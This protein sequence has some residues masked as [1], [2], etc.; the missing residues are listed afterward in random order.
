MTGI[1]SPQVV[2]RIDLRAAATGPDA[3]KADTFG[4]ETLITIQRGAASG[5]A[6]DSRFVDVGRVLVVDD[7]D[8]F[9][10]HAA[11]YQELVTA[12]T[13]SRLFCLVVGAAT[14]RA[15][16]EPGIELP[17]AATSTNSAVLWV[18]DPCGVGWRLGML[19]ATRLAVSH[20]SD[21]DGTAALA[22]LV[23]TL[24]GYQIF[25]RMFGAVAELPGRAAAA[26]TLPAVRWP[27]LPVP[28]GR[29]PPPAEIVVAEEPRPAWLWLLLLAVGCALMALIPPWEVALAVWSGVLAGAAV[30]DPVRRFRGFPSRHAAMIAAATIGTAAG[31][32]AAAAADPLA[33]LG[34]RPVAA[35]C[36]SAA[37]G[38]IALAAAALVRRSS[39]G[40]PRREVRRLPAE[41][42]GADSPDPP[43]AE[44][45]PPDSAEEDLAAM[46]T[47][48][49]AA[50]CRTI[51]ADAD[52]EDFLQLNAPGQLPL[53]DGTPQHARLVAFAPEAARETIMETMAEHVVGNAV[54]GNEVEWTAT[55][56][57][58]GIIR[59]VAVR[60][61]TLWTSEAAATSASTVIAID[62]TNGGDRARETL[63]TWLH[64]DELGTQVLPSDDG[65]P[66]AARLPNT[67]AAGMLMHGITDWLR[68]RNNETAVMFTRPDGG[69]RTLTAAEAKTATD[70]DIDDIVTAIA[71]WLMSA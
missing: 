9:A 33:H 28:A 17:P 67:A 16:A 12:P 25:D 58:I 71:N 24:A 19:T 5:G 54:A 32:I 2:I 61:G 23:D 14:E 13:L 6:H 43:P 45:E 15:L 1:R 38:V 55:G 36:S 41:G 20:P 26:A 42:E 51:S 39:L 11:I 63:A 69:T 49:V 52:D 48:I 37:L 7:T 53:L 65:G 70:D 34:V 66:M 46:V 59:L 64:D 40:R 56:D 62:V 31:A 21:P 30:T 68:G 27:D 8:A 50:A 29:P 60:P 22:E 57:L 3:V 35:Y 47:A 44:A 18:G 10:K 4:P